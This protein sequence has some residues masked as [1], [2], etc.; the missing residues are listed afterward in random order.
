MDGPGTVEVGKDGE[1]FRVTCCPPDP[2][3]PVQRFAEFRRAWGHA[4]GIRVVTGRRKVD[5]TGEG[6]PDGGHP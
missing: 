3:H 4:G 1:G 6:V 5:L 2:L